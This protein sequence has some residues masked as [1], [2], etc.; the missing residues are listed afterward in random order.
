MQ[1]REPRSWRLLRM[2]TSVFRREMGAA[3]DGNPRIGATLK[4]MDRSQPLPPHL[5]EHAEYEQQA[6]K[7]RDM[8]AAQSSGILR[9]KLLALAAEFQSLADGMFL[10][11]R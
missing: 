1:S 5:K 3:V 9:D 4:G 8:A 2:H 10:P 7:L 6:T 11:R